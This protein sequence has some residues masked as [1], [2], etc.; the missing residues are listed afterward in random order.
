MGRQSP[1]FSKKPGSDT[2][3]SGFHIDFQPLTG[4]TRSFSG[5]RP[6]FG[7]PRR[8][9][10]KARFPFD[11][12][13]RTV[14]GRF[15]AAGEAV[16]ETTGCCRA[17]ELAAYRL[18]GEIGRAFRIRRIRR[19]GRS[20]RCLP[21]GEPALSAG[22]PRGQNSSEMSLPVSYRAVFRSVRLRMAQLLLPDGFRP[23]R[24]RSVPGN[25]GRLRGW[26]GW[27]VNDNN[28]LKC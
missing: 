23:G 13:V 28:R 21:R 18:A 11:R 24:S 2:Y 26:P 27:T 10:A 12:K 6:R 20:R 8:G 16:S 5:R 3:S 14:P 1:L 25:R 4:P 15:R 17:L 22:E 9:D 19:P 7:Q